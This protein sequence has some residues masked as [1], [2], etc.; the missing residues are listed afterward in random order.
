MKK[1][2]AAALAVLAVISCSSPKKVERDFP[3]VQ[4]PSVLESPEERMEY[5]AAHFFDAF[6]RDT[7]TPYRCDSLFYAGVSSEQFEKEFASWMI[8][9]SELPRQTAYSAIERGY[10]RS[11]PAWNGFI[12]CCEK[13][14]YDANSPFRD[15]DF[16]GVVARLRLADS[17]T[18]AALLKGLERDA[19]ICALNPV[20]CPAADFRFADRFGRMHTLYEVQAEIT[21]LVFSNPGCH[22]C[23]EIREA[24]AGTLREFAESG[25]VKVVNI[26]PDEE[27][28]SWR[29]YLPNY[30]KEWLC[31]YDPDMV[32]R[33]ETLYSLRAI[34]SIYL[35]DSEK[36][37]I[38]KDCPTDRMLAYINSLPR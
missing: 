33:G 2:L 10:K 9:L 34:P 13:Y 37:V 31:G 6:S 4:V 29:E 11:G 18:P 35:L 12:R 5:S 3:R 23:E 14:M 27:L 8:L 20:G 22:A 7:L 1:I 19:R 32:L 17:R 25:R 24:F 30:P 21:L 15:E 28:D 38:L 36:R 16:Y 26:Y